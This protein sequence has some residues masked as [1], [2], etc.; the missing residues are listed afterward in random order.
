MTENVLQNGMEPFQ[1]PDCVPL[2]DLILTIKTGGIPD[3][4]PALDEKWV[5]ERY[6]LHYEVPNIYDSNGTE[7]LGAK[8]HWIEI[9]GYMIDDLKWVLTIPFYRFWSNVVFNSSILD[10]LVSFLQEAP[11]YYALESFPNDSEMQNTLETL[12]HY[13]LLIFARLVTN[14]ESPTEYMMV[15]YLG[16]VLYD[17]FIF[18]VP[19]IYDLCQLYG[20]ENEKTV[21]KILNSL[22]TIQPLYNVDI[23]KSVPYLVEALGNVERKFQERPSYLL[24]EAVPLLNEPPIEITKITLFSLEDMILYVLDIS[25]TITIFLKNYPL[26]IKKYRND[27]F[28]NEIVSIYENTIPKMYKKLN[29]LAYNEENLTKFIE[30]RHRLDVTRI[31]LLHLYRTL[32]HEPVENIHQKLDTLTEDEIKDR[33]DDY[34]NLLSN[35]IS[36]KEFITDYHQFYPVGLDLEELSKI[37]PELDTI[38]RNYILQAVYAAIGDSQISFI[39]S[40][41]NKKE[42]IAGPSNVEINQPSTSKNIFAENVTLKPVRRSSIEIASLISEVKDILNDLGE[43]FI[44]MCLKHYNYDTAAVINAVLEQTLPSHLSELDFFL[45]YIPPDTEEEPAPEVVNHDII[46]ERLNVFD[47]DEFDIMN[48]DDIDMSRIHKGKRKDKYRNMNELLNDKSEIRKVSD[49]YRKYSLVV[50]NY[51]DEYDDTYDSHD[52]RGTTQD[53]IA[54]SRAFT[55]PRV[56]LAKEKNITE[57]EDE[58]ESDSENENN[59]NGVNNKD[60]FVQNPAELRAKAEQRRQAG[61]GKRPSNDVVGKPKGQGQDK[62]VT[63]NRDKKNAHKATRANHNRR[64]GAQ[65]KQRH[66]MI[67]S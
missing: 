21:S 18:T 17:H 13:V 62:E 43:G 51:D 55:T 44:Q 63:I 59:S 10:A 66:G 34:L 14:K 61:R 46:S 32:V 64:A 52:V 56:L 5:E 38:K 19:I 40:S 65:W 24:D 23:E 47:N 20:R 4:V 58:N 28:I 12:R 50:D 48:R 33:V 11:P 42:S 31:E 41:N 9:M 60:N 49:I 25:S 22:F 37:C 27:N 36:E 3:L 35:A 2:E 45:P 6:F 57:S 26:A 39:L 8:E 7:I 67:H 30:L 15:P 1:N 16:K 53:D 29:E 54:E